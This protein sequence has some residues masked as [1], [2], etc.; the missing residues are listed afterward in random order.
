MG[1][2]ALKKAWMN[3]ALY[4]KKESAINEK[5]RNR[6]TN[7]GF[8]ILSSNCIGGIIYHRLGKEF[9]SPTINL[10]LSNPDF[11]NFCVHLDEYL[12]EELQ[13]IKTEKNH[14]VA[15]LSPHGLPSITIFFNH[16]HT[17]EDAH[18]DWTRRKARIHRDNLFLI[19]YNLDGITLEELHQLETVPCRNKV[20]FSAVPLP[21][22]SWS[23]CIKPNHRKNGMCYIDRDLWGVR[24]F[25]KH[26]DY[27][28]WLNT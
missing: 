17:E 5:A 1:L 23:C 9:L 27:V 28:T 13:F 6:L 22:I 18:S 16:A 14:P 8:T 20:V 2:A 10:H 7:D 4:R 11:V 3:T 25:E 26:F 24:T 15:V 12:Q 21:E 19:L